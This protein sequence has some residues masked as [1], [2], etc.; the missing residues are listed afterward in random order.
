MACMQ[1]NSC[2]DHL[3][4]VFI[5]ISIVQLN[6]SQIKLPHRLCSVVVTCWA[7]YIWHKWYIMLFLKFWPLSIFTQDASDTVWTFWF[8][9]TMVTVKFEKVAMM[10]KTFL[11]SL[12]G[13]TLVKSRQ[14]K[15]KALLTTRESCV[16]FGYI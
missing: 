6:L 5:K 11:P 3:A 8:G 16:G 13:T 1:A 7:P 10:T 9:G 2:F 15:Y 14:A 12:L 4:K